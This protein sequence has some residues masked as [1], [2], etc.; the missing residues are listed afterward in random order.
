METL[1][2]TPVPMLRSPSQPPDAAPSNVL[3]ATRV[4]VQELR[5]R[6]LVFYSGSAWARAQRS[7]SASE[8]R[9]ATDA[10]E[11][12]AEDLRAPLLGLVGS[13]ERAKGEGALSEIAN[14]TGEA[15]MRFVVA[16]ESPMRVLRRALVLYGS[17]GM[18]LLADLEDALARVREVAR[19]LLAA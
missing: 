13:L 14:A 2:C 4:A 5:N 18:E 8:L 7:T 1:R 17:D 6:L 15:S 16:A 10:L 3:D 19:S 11:R 12:H 9:S